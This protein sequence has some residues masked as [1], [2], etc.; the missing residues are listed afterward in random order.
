MKNI[1]VTMLST[2]VA[3]MSFAAQAVTIDFD[4][5]DASSGAVSGPAL[6]NYL[7]SYNVTAS[8]ITPGLELSVQDDQVIYGG[9][10]V[11]APSQRNVFVGFGPASAVAYLLD[12]GAA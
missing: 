3:V 7:A 1:F 12:L 5:L 6:A 11:S 8:P 10:V 9:G 4:A 2:A